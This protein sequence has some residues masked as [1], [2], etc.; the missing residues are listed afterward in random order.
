MS[1]EIRHNRTKNQKNTNKLAI[2]AIVW[3]NKKR[4]GYV[5]YSVVIDWDKRG[6]EFAY[7]LSVN[8]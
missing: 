4:T 8:A 7:D 1:T 5:R 2:N 6:V 3:Y